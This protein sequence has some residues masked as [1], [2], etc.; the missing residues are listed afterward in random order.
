MSP[1]P[2][3]TSTTT[4]PLLCLAAGNVYSNK[5]LTSW[6]FR[7]CAFNMMEEQELDKKKGQQGQ[8]KQDFRNS[9]YSKAFKAS[10]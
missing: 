8:Q 7:Q 3:S 2:S 5:A 9:S 4:P 6:D 10:S 1:Q